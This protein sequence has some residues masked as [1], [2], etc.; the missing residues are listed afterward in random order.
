M[1]DSEMPEFIPDNTKSQEI[2]HEVEKE[3][4]QN[5]EIKEEEEVVDSG[6]DQNVF[7][8]LEYQDIII[9]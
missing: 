8:L 1:F 4:K 2:A 6:I 7:L 5:E 3:A 9:P